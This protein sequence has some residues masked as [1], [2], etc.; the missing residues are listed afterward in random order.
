MLS[1]SAARIK[2]QAAGNIFFAI[3]PGNFSLIAVSPPLLQPLQLT[4]RV[5]RL[6][7]TA[8]SGRTY[9]AQY[10]STLAATAWTDLLPDITAI[11]STAS[12]TD[13]SSGAPQRFYRI[14]LLP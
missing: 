5:V 9:R 10:K 7:W 6:T 4:N 2:I 3:S 8:I 1:S 11:T 13:A 14:L 12:T